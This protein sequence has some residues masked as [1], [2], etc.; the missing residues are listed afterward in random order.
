MPARHYCRSASRDRSLIFSLR[1][2]DRRAADANFC[3]HNLQPH[4]VESPF[5]GGSDLWVT[6]LPAMDG[7]IRCGVTGTRAVEKWAF[8]AIEGERPQRFA[9]IDT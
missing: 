5:S 1:N 2:G 7:T 6:G 8:R 4:P 3:L 9:I